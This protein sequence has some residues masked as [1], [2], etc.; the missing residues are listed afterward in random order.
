M[1]N[2]YP[3]VIALLAADNVDFRK[4]VYAIAMRD[5]KAVIDAVFGPIQETLDGK[6]R[7]LCLAGRPIDAIKL[8]RAETGLGMKDAQ[9][10]VERLRG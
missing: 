3:E 6:L 1:N 4:I 5:P 9:E 7:Q 2:Y 8:L 10:Y